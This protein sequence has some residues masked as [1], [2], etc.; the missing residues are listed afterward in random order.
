MLVTLVTVHVSCELIKAIGLLIVKRARLFSTTSAFNQ[1]L[2]QIKLVNDVYVLYMYLL[3]FLVLC[4]FHSLLLTS[5]YLL[6]LTTAIHGKFCK[7]KKWIIL[8]TEVRLLC[9]L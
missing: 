6:L 2:L 9:Y 4:T 3:A 5:H 1:R 8:C 7:E